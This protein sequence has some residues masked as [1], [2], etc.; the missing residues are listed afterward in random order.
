MLL[1]RVAVKLRS[2]AVVDR[3][4]VGR[5]RFIPHNSVKCPVQ[6]VG[7]IRFFKGLCIKEWEKT[8]LERGF[9]VRLSLAVVINNQI[10]PIAAEGL[11]VAGSI[12]SRIEQA[13]GKTEQ[14]V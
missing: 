6:V 2:H 5:S 1:D 4:P 13:A 9:E 10:P 14:L 8:G 7:N 11:P 12:C 3:I